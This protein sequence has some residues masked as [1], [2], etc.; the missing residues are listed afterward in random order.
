[1]SDQVLSVLLD[2]YPA[3]VEIQPQ[4]RVSICVVAM[5]GSMNDITFRRY[6]VG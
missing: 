3:K 4:I 2:R 5:M 1:M 6:V